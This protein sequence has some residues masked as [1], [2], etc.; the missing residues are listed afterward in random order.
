MFYVQLC[1]TFSETNVKG[2]VQW[3]LDYPETFG[4]GFEWIIECL[5]NKEVNINETIINIL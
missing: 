1:T 3:N 2:L 4:L 5:D